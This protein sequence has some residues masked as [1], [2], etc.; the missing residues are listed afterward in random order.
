MQLVGACACII[1]RS[2]IGADQQIVKAD[3]MILKNQVNDGPS[4]NWKPRSPFD[5]EN[6]E[7]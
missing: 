6:Q 5:K 4:Q 2:K 3:H 7:N 1:T